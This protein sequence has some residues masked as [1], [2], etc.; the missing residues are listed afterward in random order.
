MRHG[1]ATSSVWAAWAACLGDPDCRVL[2]LFLPILFS[3]SLLKYAS[4]FSS[5]RRTAR[6]NLGETQADHI[7]LILPAAPCM[8]PTQ[9]VGSAPKKTVSRSLLSR[10]AFS[11]PTPAPTGNTV[12]QSLGSLDHWVLLTPSA[13]CDSAENDPPADA[14]RLSAFSS[15]DCN[16]SSLC[17][18]HPPRHF[19]LLYYGPLSTDG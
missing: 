2:T 17:S 19:V 3:Y 12:H 5:L 13:V 16:N 11:N 10:I 4:F 9:T 14:V 1:G 15:W 8:S 7:P 18:S 6:A